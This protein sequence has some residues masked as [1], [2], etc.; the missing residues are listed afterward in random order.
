MHRVTNLTEVSDKVDRS[1]GKTCWMHSCMRKLMDVSQILPH[2]LS[3]PF[4]QMQT[5]GHDDVL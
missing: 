5:S 4:S 3:N 2:D 1:D